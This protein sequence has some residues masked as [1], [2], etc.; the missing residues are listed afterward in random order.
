MRCLISIRRHHT[1]HTQEDAAA[2]E[3]AV[4]GG[5]SPSNVAWHELGEAGLD[6]TY[7]T[8]AWCDRV[9]TSDDLERYGLSGWVKPMDWYPLTGGRTPDG[10][11]SST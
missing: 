1:T 7:H 11:D 4:A 3:K 5:E 10:I 8:A 2:A 6:C 9:A